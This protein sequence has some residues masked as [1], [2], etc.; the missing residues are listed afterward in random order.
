[1]RFL[2]KWYF[3]IYHLLKL[4]GVFVIIL[5]PSIVKAEEINCENY[6]DVET[7]SATGPATTG[8]ATGMY[9]I[10]NKKPMDFSYQTNFPIKY[11]YI[12]YDI[13]EEIENNFVFYYYYYNT[14]KTSWVT[15]NTNIR[16]KN[17]L[18]L[19]ITAF[20]QGNS[21]VTNYIMWT[22]ENNKNKLN[23]KKIYKF[24]NETTYNYCKNLLYPTP[25][26]PT[27]SNDV[28]GEFTS[29]YTDRL[30]YLGTESM[31]NPYIEAMIVIIIG[32]VV[33][34]IFLRL[35]HIRGGYRK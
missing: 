18:E 17:T 13:E 31:N 6:I 19:E 16:N 22:N 11:Y 10:A 28:I 7:I 24:D 14:T 15:Y 8:L 12:F 2:K 1:M 23:G 9:N 30:E 35:F 26:P 21:S 33:L 27:P 34:E 5:V 3:K 25:E 29:I 32:F 20:N 4:I